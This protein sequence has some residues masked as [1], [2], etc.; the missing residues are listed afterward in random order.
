MHESS[1][2]L[3]KFARAL[4]RCKSRP[5]LVVRDFRSDIC[6]IPQADFLSPTPLSQTLKLL[7]CT[8]RASRGCAFYLTNPGSC[9]SGVRGELHAAHS[10]FKH[11]GRQQRIPCPGRSAA[12]K[13][14]GSESH[15]LIPFG[16]PNGRDYCDKSVTGKKWVG[17]EHLCPGSLSSTYFEFRIRIFNLQVLNHATYAAGFA[18]DNRWGVAQP[19]EIFSLYS[20]Y[21]DSEQIMTHTHSFLFL[22]YICCRSVSYTPSPSVWLTLNF[23]IWRVCSLYHWCYLFL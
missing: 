8:D 9:T 12:S 23:T 15:P 18:R 7:V 19:I 5:I 14:P 11:S 22:T 17:A 1:N 16:P 20:S 21:D 4:L 10:S 13:Y 6:F 2:P 3:A